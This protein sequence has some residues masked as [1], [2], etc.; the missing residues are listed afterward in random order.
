M[1]NEKQNGIGLEKGISLVTKPHKIYIIP[2]INQSFNELGCFKNFS[3]KFYLNFFPLGLLSE[4]MC[5]QVKELIQTI[6]KRP[7]LYTMQTK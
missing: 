1:V 2:K 5:S 4:M 6:R 7:R 3:I